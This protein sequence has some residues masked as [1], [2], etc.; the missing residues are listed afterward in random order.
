MSAV[1]NITDIT[2]LNLQTDYYNFWLK[3]LVFSMC[4]VING[5]HISDKHHGAEFAFSDYNCI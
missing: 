5:A 4:L 2:V 3:K 1:D